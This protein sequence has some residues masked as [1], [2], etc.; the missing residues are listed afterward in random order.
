MTTKCHGKVMSSYIRCHD[1]CVKLHHACGRCS[2]YHLSSAAS[3]T[4][5]KLQLAAWAARMGPDDLD[6]S[7]ARPAA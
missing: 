6:V 5:A 3:S 7:C 2:M 4:E 1:S